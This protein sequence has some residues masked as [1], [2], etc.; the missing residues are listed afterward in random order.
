MKRAGAVTASVMS[1]DPMVNGKHMGTSQ[2]M[3]ADSQH[4]YEKMAMSDQSTDSTIMN[5][6]VDPARSSQKDC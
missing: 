4:L 3:E 2:L 1:V 6:A 5:T